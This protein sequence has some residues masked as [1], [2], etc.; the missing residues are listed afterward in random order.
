M[1]LRDFRRQLPVHER[2]VVELTANW[3][4]VTAFRSPRRFLLARIHP[5]ASDHGR[6]RRGF[7]HWGRSSDAEFKSGR[8]IRTKS[9]TYELPPTAIAVTKEFSDAAKTGI[10]QASGAWGFPEPLLEMCIRSDR[11]DQEIT[12]LHFEGAGPVFHEEEPYKDTYDRFIDS[13]Q[14]AK[15]PIRAER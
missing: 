15:M 13:G 7:A 12:L 4:S 14:P 5:N 10:E 1:P 9:S 3:R 11:Y 2:R 6:L 8:F